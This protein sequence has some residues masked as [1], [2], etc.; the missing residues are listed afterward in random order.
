MSRGKF[1]ECLSRRLS[2]AGKR[3]IVSGS[4]MLGEFH[5]LC[6]LE[7]LDYAIEEIEKAAKR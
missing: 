6:L 7:G 3:Y 4:A 5:K 2:D 1:I